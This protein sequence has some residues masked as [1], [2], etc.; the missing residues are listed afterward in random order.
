MVTEA[1][2]TFSSSLPKTPSPHFP[3]KVI[4][5]SIYDFSG[6]V[7]DFHPKNI[8]INDPQDQASRWSSSAKDL[9]QFITLRI[10]PNI[11]G[12]MLLPL[13]AVQEITFGKYHLPHVCNLKEFKVF[14]S[15]DGR[16]WKEAL[17]QG[18]K[19]DGISETFPLRYLIDPT[20]AP[21]S[22]Y[23]VQFVKIVPISTW[24]IGFNFG[25]WFVQ[26]KGTQERNQITT[27]LERYLQSQYMQS[28]LAISSTMMLHKQSSNTVIVEKDFEMLF[29]RFYNQ[30]EEMKY[31][32]DFYSLI[33]E[34]KNTPLLDTLDLS[35]IDKKI[36]KICSLGTLQKGHHNGGARSRCYTY[37]WTQIVRNKEEDLWPAARGGHQLVYDP[38]SKKLFLF[39]G[40]DGTREFADFWSFD[41][42]TKRWTMISSD[43]S[44]E[45]GPS[46]RSVHR[47]VIDVAGQ[48]MYCLGRYF[49]PERHP[50]E[51]SSSCDFYRCDLTNFTWELLS[52]NTKVNIRPHMSS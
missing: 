8:L 21:P 17:H 1:T 52:T 26:L 3:L 25:I 46:P 34:I 47:C 9:N 38:H 44:K 45:C 33:L 12:T 48:S 19:N 5:A 15:I 30:I 7:K 41:C 11:Q 2:Y 49:S 42:D 40:W 4:S 50:T 43:T 6:Y 22:I 16:E 39:G 28:C 31:G 36:E 24:G 14:V 13:A 29:H 20:A 37:K 35:K 27:S 32:R 23:P 51:T 10:A 18:L